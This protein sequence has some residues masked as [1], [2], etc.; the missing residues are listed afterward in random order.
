M[1]MVWGMAQSKLQLR[2]DI[3][4]LFIRFSVVMSSRSLF[5]YKMS[6]KFSCL[7]K[8]LAE[9]EEE[10]RMIAVPARNGS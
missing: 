6:L 10:L 3:A 8:Y 9:A 4:H 7:S 2:Y 5:Q 1:Y